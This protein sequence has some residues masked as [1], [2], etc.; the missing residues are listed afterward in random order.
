[1][2]VNPILGVAEIGAEALVPGGVEAPAAEG[3]PAVEV[4]C[5]GGEVQGVVAGARRPGVDADEGMLVEGEGARRPGVG[6][7][8]GP[9]R[10]GEARHRLGVEADAA[11]QGR[12]VVLAP[13]YGHV[14]ARHQATTTRTVCWMQIRRRIFSRPGKATST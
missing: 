11:R 13:T 8:A 2:K 12:D 7:D 10:A 9:P 5:L 3:Q 1:M 6:A 4:S 14:R